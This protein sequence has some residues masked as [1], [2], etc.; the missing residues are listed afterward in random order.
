L[1][2]LRIGADRAERIGAL[3]VEAAMAAGMDFRARL[4]ERGGEAFADG[5]VGLEEIEGVALGAARADG[6]KL[7]QGFDE[8]GEGRGVFGHEKKRAELVGMGL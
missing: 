1:V 3:R 6:G 7:A 5:G 4:G 2:A 8:F